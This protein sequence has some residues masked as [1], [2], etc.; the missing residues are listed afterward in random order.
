MLKA[1]W[2]FWVL[3]V[4]VCFQVFMTPT[5]AVLAQDASMLRDTMYE[6]SPE[7]V[8]NGYVFRNSSDQLSLTGIRIHERN[9]IAGKL[10]ATMIVAAA[11]AV[12]SSDREYLGTEYGYGYRVDY[13]RM[14]SS[15]EMAAEAAARD[16]AIDATASNMYQFDLRFYL[17]P[18][19][20]KDQANGEGF[21]LTLYPFSWSFGDQRDWVFEFGF[22]WASIYGGLMDKRL[23]G[24]AGPGGVDVNGNPLPADPGQREFTY[25]NVGMPF[26]FVIP[27]TSFLYLD[28]QWDMNFLWLFGADEG[29][30]EEF[31]APFHSNLTFNLGS[32]FFVRGGATLSGFNFSNDVG[33]QAEAG[34]R[35]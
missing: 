8:H 3:T 32:R 33:Y 11:M 34:V 18:D 17:K 31:D 30:R 20:L 1:R 16:D 2:V 21:S 28:N 7:W 13:Y 4:A 25:T 29:D 14:K 12:G 24:I 23:K 5:T 6:V 9:G 35:F 19:F 10:L 27:I 26:R 22:Q 15:E